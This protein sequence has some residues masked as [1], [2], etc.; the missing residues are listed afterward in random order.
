MSNIA[1][2]LPET[3]SDGTPVHEGDIIAEGKV[4]DIIWEGKAEIITRPLGV[5]YV[6]SRKKLTK[7]NTILDKPEFYNV[8]QI[9]DGKVKLIEDN[10]EDW[11][12]EFIS[13]THKTTM[14]F[15]LS[16]W[17]GGFYGWEDIYKV[18]SI[19]DFGD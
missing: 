5:V 14:S 6:G 2:E 8:M 9:R 12:E 15:H 17:D 10:L 4:G 1:I 11:A 3:Y 7:N 16:K 13:K 18:G 19:Y